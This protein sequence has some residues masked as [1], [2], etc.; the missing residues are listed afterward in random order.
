MGFHY[1]SSDGGGEKEKYK[2]IYVNKIYIRL[3]R[4][5]RGTWQPNRRS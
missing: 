1:I 4:L 2:Y 5:E 3:P